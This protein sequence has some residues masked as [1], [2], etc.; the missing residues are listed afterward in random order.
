MF[1]TIVRF[2][3]DILGFPASL[4]DF[5]AVNPKLGYSLDTPRTVCS[6]SVTCWHEW[7]PAGWDS[8]VG[9]LRGWRKTQDSYQGFSI[10]VPALVNLT[11]HQQSEMWKCDIRQVEAICNS[12]SP[13]NVFKE[14]DSFAFARCKGY[15]DD[16][17]L[18]QI[19]HNL[20][21][22]EVRIMQ[23]GRGDFFKY[24]YWDNRVCLI[25]CGGSHHFATAR[26]LAGILGQPVQLCGSL[27]AYSLNPTAV[28]ELTEQFKLFSV[29]NTLLWDELFEIF[30]RIQVTWFVGELPHPHNE[31]CV[32]MFPRN[33]RHSMRIANIL[34]DAGIPN[35]GKYL[36][37]LLIQQKPPRR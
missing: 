32:L 37:N 30:N 36:M 1:S 31:N 7:K 11:K 21:H 3:Q 35:L 8:Q 28:K 27:H 13:L 15:L 33:N 23:H 22:N 20:A 6:D 17:S 19:Y 5:L 24:H 18:E 4:K 25:N 2:I 10:C 16:V 26:Y 12:K 34:S 29:D 9:E 14:L